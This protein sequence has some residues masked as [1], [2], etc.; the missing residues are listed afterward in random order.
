MISNDI[1]LAASL[2]RND[3]LIGLPTETVYGLAGNAFSEKAVKLIYQVKNRPSNHPLIVHIANQTNLLQIA[4][5]VN[6]NAQLLAEQFWPGPLT[7]LLPKKSSLPTFIT[8]GNEQVAVR[9]PNHPVAISLLK[10]IDFPLV[11]PSANPFGS[12]SPTTAQHVFD[13]FKNDI[14][15]TLDG[16]ACQRGIES[17]IIGFKD[18]QPILYRY[19][20]IPLEEIEKVIGPVKIF[21]KNDVNPQAP[22]MVAKHYA[23]KTKLF[24]TEDI[25]SVISANPSKKIGL[26]LFDQEINHPKVKYQLTLSPTGSLKQAAANLYLALHQL[27]RQDL[28][29]I[30]AQKLPATEL[31]NTINDRLER[32]AKN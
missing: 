6:E 18:N 29:V 28:D 31:G 14:K 17:T 16:G 26:L 5:S 9:I 19:G 10:A 22:G 32:A 21:N 4:D 8:G 23:P 3:E 20:S 11:A 27:D 13:Y 15:L 24:L 2:L 25:M 7:L 1:E 12:I 30:I